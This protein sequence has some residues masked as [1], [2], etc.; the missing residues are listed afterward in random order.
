[1]WLGFLF[2]KIYEQILLIGKNDINFCLFVSDFQ[3]SVCC[4]VPS[5]GVGLP[6][7]RGG[8]Q[9]SERANER[10]HA[11]TQRLKLKS[12][13]TDSKHIHIE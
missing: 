8:R 12:D 4:A 7:P 3:H 9:H 6:E 13:Q 5:E 1:L 10:T 2:E 11:R